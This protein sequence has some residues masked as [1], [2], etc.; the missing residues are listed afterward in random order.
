[1]F[2]TT[3]VL[4]DTLPAVD[5]KGCRYSQVKLQALGDA[6][7]GRQHR[8]KAMPASCCQLAVSRSHMFDVGSGGSG[9]TLMVATVLAFVEVRTIGVAYMTQCLLWRLLLILLDN[10]RARHGRHPFSSPSA[11]PAPQTR[12]SSAV[13]SPHLWPLTHGQHPQGP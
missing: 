2:L 1:M 4:Q 7:C 6:C 12:S 13:H 10:P 5:S 11:R 3:L 8:T 9:D